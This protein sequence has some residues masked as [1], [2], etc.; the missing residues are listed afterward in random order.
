MLVDTIQTELLTWIFSHGLRILI[1]AVGFL[2]VQRLLKTVI[3][4]V[5]DRIVRKTYHSHSEAAMTKRQDTL[6]NVFYV[7]LKVLL[8]IAAGLMILSEIGLDIAPLL[9]GAGIA[10]LAF[11]FGGQ[12]LVR[13]LISGLFIILEDQF[14]KGDVVTIAGI[15]GAVEDINLRRT[16]L[17]DLDGIEHHIPNGTITTT[18]NMTKFWSRIHMNIGIAYEAPI[19]KVIEVLTT[20]CKTFAESPD[21]KDDIIKTPVVVGIDEFA[22]SAIIYKILGDIKPGRQWDAMRALRKDIKL[23]LDKASIDIPYPH[24]TIVKK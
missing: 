12:Y 5:L 16:I 18:S 10:G 4:H 21:W 7:S 19:E 11:G 24:R 2:I 23:A 9:A 20:T 14:R 15:S 8:W 22:D 3:H 1:I 17:R 13:D 6:E